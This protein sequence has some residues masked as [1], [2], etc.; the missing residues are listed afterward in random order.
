MVLKVVSRLNFSSCGNRN[1]FSFDDARLRQNGRF[2]QS[3]FKRFKFNI[4]VPFII[5][6][7]IGG[8][9]LYLIHFLS[10]L[11]KTLNYFQ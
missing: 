11:P 8:G 9:L 7:R 3:N 6:S 10:D 1:G 4:L 2:R 5:K